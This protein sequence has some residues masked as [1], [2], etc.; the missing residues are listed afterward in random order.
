MIGVYSGESLVLVATT[1]GD[2]CL[3][4]NKINIAEQDR[5]YT[6]NATMRRVRITTVVVE[7]Q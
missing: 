2:V 6:Y 1:L 5:Q 4:M 3:S 7:K